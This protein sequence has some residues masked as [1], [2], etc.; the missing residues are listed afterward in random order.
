MN[1][2]VCGASLGEA[3]YR[4]TVSDDPK[5]SAVTCYRQACGRKAFAIAEMRLLEA[6]G[7]RRSEDLR[8]TK[9]GIHRDPHDA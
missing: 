3:F 9:W 2:D 7:R 6:R 5:A 8:L 4:V 1:C